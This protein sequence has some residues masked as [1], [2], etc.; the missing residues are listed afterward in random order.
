[1]LTRCI[2]YLRFLNHWVLAV[3]VVVVVVVVAA[4]LSWSVGWGYPVNM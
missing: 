3:V 2:L 4:S 1:M